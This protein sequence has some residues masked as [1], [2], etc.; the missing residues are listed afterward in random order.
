MSDSATSRAIP[1]SNTRN[2][3]KSRLALPTFSSVDPHQSRSY[4]RDD[5]KPESS[6]SGSLRTWSKARRSGSRGRVNGSREKGDTVQDLRPYE[7]PF[8]PEVSQKMESPKDVQS[9]EAAKAK[10]AQDHTRAGRRTSNRSSSGFLLGSIGRS[11]R[12]PKIL[13]QKPTSESSADRKGKSKSTSPAVSRGGDS[14]NLQPQQTP[15]TRLRQSES[16]ASSS[17]GS[18][19]LSTEVT[20]GQNGG[21]HRG[22][23]GQA[24]ERLTPF[25]ANRASS[26]EVPEHKIEIRKRPTTSVGYDTDP[27]QIVNMALTL[28]EARRRQASERR[29]VSANQPGRSRV[30]SSATTGTASSRQA[31]TGSVAQ[32]LQTQRT[33][34]MKSTPGTPLIPSEALTNPSVVDDDV[35]M[36][37]DLGPGV[38][39]ATK[40][41]VERART[42]FEL[43]YEHRRLLSHLPPVRRP[44]SKAYTHAQ[45]KAYNPLQYIR[46]RKLRIWEKTPID[47]EVDG[48]HDVERVRNWVNAVI[49]GHA[50]KEFDVDECVRLPP[51]KEQQHNE[52]SRDTSVSASKERQP[53]RTN[54]DSVFRTRRPRSDWITAPADILADCFWLEQGM[55]KVKILDRDNNNI[56]PPNTQ[57]KF[58]GWRNRTPV[59]LPEGLQQ[60]SPP[61]ER[62][63]EHDSKGLLHPVS[64]LP[65]FKSAHQKPSHRG[66]RS[67]VKDSIAAVDEGG[68]SKGLKTLMDDSSSDST[69]GSSGGGS[70]GA[71][72]GRRRLR[73]KRRQQE[74]ISPG[75][76]PSPPHARQL[77]DTTASDQSA[78]ASRHQS[79]RTSLDHGTSR[80][81]RFLK[82]E[83]AS[84]SRGSSSLTREHRQRDSISKF[85]VLDEQPR[86]SAEYDTTAPNSPS[87]PVWPSI[88]INL[89]SPPRSRSASPVKRHGHVSSILRPLHRHS[90]N[91]SISTKDFSD[92]KKSSGHV[93]KEDK[94]K[95]E[96]TDASRGTSP[97]TRGQS[98]GTKRDSHMPV[99]VAV[100]QQP[101][102]RL[103]TRTS[104]HPNEHGKIRGMFKGGRIAELVGHEVSKVGDYI[105]K[106]EPPTA[107]AR[108]Y[109]ADSGKSGYESDSETEPMN[110][111]VIKTPH[112]HMLRSRSSTLSSAKSDSP[113]LN[114]KTSP[115]SGG[116][117]KYNN[118]NLPSFTS[119]FDKDREAQ[120]RKLSHLTPSSVDG[121]HISRQAA[122]HRS[123]SK[124]PRLDRLAPPRLNTGERSSSGNRLTPSR[125]HESGLGLVLTRSQEASNKLNTALGDSTPFASGVDLGRMST[126]ALDESP[127]VTFRDINRAQAFIYSSASKA[128]EIGRRADL[129]RK[130]PDYLTDAMAGFQTQNAHTKADL[131]M[132]SRREEKVVAAQ[133]IMATLTVEASKFE[134]ML[135]KFSSKTAPSLHRMLQELEDQVDN[136]M[137]PRVRHSADEASEL[138]IRLASTTTL[139]VK[140]VNEAI[141]SA[142]VARTGGPLRWIRGA[143][144]KSIEMAVVSLLWGIWAVV[145][146]IRILMAVMTG[147]GRGFRWLVWWN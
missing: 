110:G 137:T 99:S 60:P 103:T 53:G 136:K 50:D 84:K 6:T 25:T 5:E 34:S 52:S 146:I 49:E 145:S 14:D 58:S 15:I 126:H 119:P 13:Q 4:S 134:E 113:N 147:V 93:P 17:I 118:P 75:Q 114:S 140:G 70:P 64:E 141:D 98:P 21:L 12:L 33:P 44:N 123:A 7:P 96:S 94:V 111:N 27:A 104:T 108:R 116:R 23:V 3:G 124:S 115:G 80:V 90:K 76:L 81:G 143:W 57:F 87:H 19:P 28:S 95:D 35:V 38:S 106:K 46:N 22:P 142:L 56:Y 26:S 97:M 29:Y 24:A 117:P 125:S 59:H 85:P 133:H 132:V 16:R 105:W 138:S 71:E 82:R 10:L 66:K 92:F 39:A 30:V 41:R 1:A 91:E 107:Y 37:D 45:S 48:W 36:E 86:N 128:K 83:S 65:M 77:G 135:Q 79:K 68:F 89:E 131:A 42:F 31:Q 109:S 32:Y 67:K 100:E 78:P 51:L 9:E 144:Y 55:N 40:A 127:Y 43:A 47:S 122:E 120:E 129:P 63:H 62:E 11:G 101:M 112:G 121:D 102:S 61:P 139:A 72:R 20:D 130:R 18:S 88:A 8:M 74:D 73:K 2:D 54:Q 69:G